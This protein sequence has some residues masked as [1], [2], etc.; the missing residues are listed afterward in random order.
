MDKNELLAALH[1]IENRVLKAR[2]KDNADADDAL[3]EFIDDA[4]VSE[5]YSSIQDKCP[6]C[7]KPWSYPC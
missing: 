1:Q 7:K 5:V 2:D 3:L 4:E 6:T